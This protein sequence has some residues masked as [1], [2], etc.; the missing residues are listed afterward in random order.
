MTRAFQSRFY[1]LELT[2]G[3]QL[4][5]SNLIAELQHQSIRLY[6]T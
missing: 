1:D 6:S 5:E 3:G 4:A 2:A